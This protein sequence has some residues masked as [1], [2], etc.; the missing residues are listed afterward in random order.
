MTKKIVDTLH[1][2]ALQPLLPPSELRATNERETPSDA[3]PSKRD[4][5]RPISSQVSQLSGRLALM[6]SRS[7]NYTS[8]VKRHSRAGTWP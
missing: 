2:L 8:R 5:P 1:L 3:T 6:F 7:R 4:N